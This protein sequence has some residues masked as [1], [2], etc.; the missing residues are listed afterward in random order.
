MLCCSPACS[1]TRFQKLLAHR[2]CPSMFQPLVPTKPHPSQWYL[3]H[4]A[5]LTSSKYRHSVQTT[6]PPSPGLPSSHPATLHP[7][8]QCT[9]IPYLWYLYMDM[10]LRIT[11]I[12]AALQL[13][14]PSSLHTY[15]TSN[16]PISVQSN[17][18]QFTCLEPSL[19]VPPSYT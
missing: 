19:H 14:V 16:Y 13:H 15:W 18:N 5:T 1:I 4:S 3:Y 6:Q 9:C 2:V 17:Q 7:H 10:H 11:C 8:I 12:P